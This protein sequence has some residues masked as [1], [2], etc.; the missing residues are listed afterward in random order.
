MEYE[1]KREAKRLEV[2]IKSIA[3]LFG[4]KSEDSGEDED[5]EAM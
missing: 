1:N 5:A 2:Q 3:A 4:A